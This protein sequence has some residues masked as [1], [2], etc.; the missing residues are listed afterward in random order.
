VIFDPDEDADDDE[1]AEMFNQSISSQQSKS[2]EEK[3]KMI[4][5][6]FLFTT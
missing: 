5:E 1:I 6:D 3:I 2:A 4:N